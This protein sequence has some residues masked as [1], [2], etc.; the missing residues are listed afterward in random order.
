[1]GPRSEQYIDGFRT[2]LQIEQGM[3][4]NTC[5]SYCSDMKEFFSW[6]SSRSD[7]EVRPAQVSKDDILAYL[8][9][10]TGEAGADEGAEAISS[11]TQARILCSMRSFFTWLQMD[12]EIQDNPCD[13]LDSPKIGRYLPAVLSIEEVSAIMDSVDLATWRGRR[14]RAILEMLYGC[15]L[16]VSEASVLKISDLFLAEGFV[17]VIGKGDKQRIVPIGEQASDAVK[18]YLAVRPDPFMSSDDT[19]FLNRSGKRLSRISI[20]TMVKRQALAA[21]VVKEISPHTFRH[22]FATH[23]MEGGADLRAV[24]EMLG[25]ESVLTT[26]IYT[27]LDSSTWQKDVLEHHPMKK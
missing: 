15:G 21:G 10:R 6:L 11:R 17:R 20:F 7:A 12:G 23:L 14:D 9:A 3:S 4:V 8:A 13:G 5:N 1:M 24:Q 25:H 16:R 19:L 26:E 18:A 2:C 27:H 22:S